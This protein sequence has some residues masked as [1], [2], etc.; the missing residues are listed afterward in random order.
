MSNRIFSMKLKSDFWYKVPHSLSWEG[1]EAWRKTT[2]MHHP[3]QYWV[4][5]TVPHWITVH[6]KWRCRDAFWKTYRFFKPCH[7]DIRKAIPSEWSDIANLIVDVNFAMI[8]S[9]KKEA[10]A[11]FVDWNGTPDHCKFKKWLD[12]AAHWIKEGRPA[13][14]AQRDA[15][16]PPNPLPPEMKNKSYD[17]LYGELNKIE[18]LIAATDANILKQMIDYRDYFWT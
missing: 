18:A 12:S 6:I 14:E 7:K 8:L 3:I 2:K 17:E 9:F 4:R 10:D 16:Y 13:C 1:W 11:S 5:D 15:L